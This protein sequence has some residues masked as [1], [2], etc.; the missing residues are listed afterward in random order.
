MVIHRHSQGLLG[1]ILTDYVFIQ[2][3][4][5]LHRTGQFLQNAGRTGFLLPLFGNDFI[6]EFNTLIADVDARTGHQSA[7]R[8]LLLSA[9]R[10]MK[11]LFI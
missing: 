4:L 5:D 7:H 1:L 11:L 2:D 3:L 10:A 9:E 8:I 6:T